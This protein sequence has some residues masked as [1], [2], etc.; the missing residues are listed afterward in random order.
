MCFDSTDKFYLKHFSLY[1]E[2]SE[3]LLSYEYRRIHVKYPLFLSEF[4]DT[5]I[6]S[7]HFGKNT[8]VSIFIKICPMGAEVFPASGQTWR[9]Q[10]SLF[11]ILRTRLQ[12]VSRRNRI[13]FS[14]KIVQTIETF[15]RKY[16]KW[17]CWVTERMSCCQQSVGRL[18][19]QAETLLHGLVLIKGAALKEEVGSLWAINWELR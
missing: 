13:A 9:S 7:T 14:E 19:Q 11:A 18:Q 17:A 6:F 3:I 15:V 16:C 1:E 8:K 10:Q 2:F 4:N 12:M 5:W